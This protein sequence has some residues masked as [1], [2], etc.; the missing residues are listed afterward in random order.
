M[1]RVLYSIIF[2]VCTLT[3][4]PPLSF[5][6]EPVPMAGGEYSSLFFR[7]PRFFTFD[8]NRVQVVQKKNLDWLAQRVQTYRDLKQ[9]LQYGYYRVLRTDDNKPYVVYHPR[10]PGGGV[11]G[12]KIFGTLGGMAGA[13]IGKLVA[14]G[15]IEAT[16][17]IV[18]EEFGI[19]PEDV[20]P[21]FYYLYGT[22]KIVMTI[23]DVGKMGHSIAQ[24][25]FS[26]LLPTSPASL[27]QIGGAARDLNTV[28]NMN[29]SAE[30]TAR[31]VLELARNYAQINPQIAADIVGSPTTM[32]IDTVIDTL[33]SNIP[34][35]PEA[36]A[37]IITNAKHAT[38][39]VAGGVYGSYKSI[40]E[41]I[42]STPKEVLKANNYNPDEISR[43]LSS[44]KGGM[45]ERTVDDVV[46]NVVKTGNPHVRYGV[47]LGDPSQQTLFVKVDGIEISVPIG[48][49]VDLGKSS[50]GGGFANS[51]DQVLDNRYFKPFDHGIFLDNADTKPV[52]ES[53]G[54]AKDTVVV[55][56]EEIPVLSS[57][58]YVSFAESI[59]KYKA[60]TARS[61]YISHDEMLRQQDTTPKSEYMSHDEMLKNYD[62]YQGESWVDPRP[63]RDGRPIVYREATPRER[64]EQSERLPENFNYKEFI[65]SHT[66]IVNRPDKEQ[67]IEDIKN[68]MRDAKYYKEAHRLN[69][70]HRQALKGIKT[71]RDRYVPTINHSRGY[72][73][74]PAE[75]VVEEDPSIIKID[76]LHPERTPL[77]FGDKFEVQHPKTYEELMQVVDKEF[78]EKPFEVGVNLVEAQRYDRFVSLE[79]FPGSKEVQCGDGKLYV[80]QYLPE[81]DKSGAYGEAYQRMIA[82]TVQ[83]DFQNVQNSFTSS[84]A[85][86]GMSDVFKD[87][88][89]D[90]KS[91]ENIKDDNAYVETVYRQAYELLYSKIG[92]RAQ[93]QFTDPGPAVEE[94]M[95]RGM[96]NGPFEV[97]V[98][99]VVQTYDQNYTALHNIKD[100]MYM[101][102]MSE[103]LYEKYKDNAEFV[104]G[105]RKHMSN[106]IQE[107]KK[108]P[109]WR[110]S[111][112]SGFV[113]S[114]LAIGGV[115]FNYF[116]TGKAALAGAK[117]GSY[118]GTAF[119]AALPFL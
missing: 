112:S 62:P 104:K 26:S 81:F 98:D 28:M 67:S 66:K 99:G 29:L 105:L 58:E 19:A 12:A 27:D 52:I 71:G 13:F 101:L 33:M 73:P 76:P 97:E 77:R 1:K 108:N 55:E 18:A 24:G 102:R 61:G 118:L 110:F 10:M 3:A 9:S 7:A 119:G 87:I 8:N 88:K 43:A 53:I 15:F 31:N 72:T 49:K 39:L 4:Q 106:I 95:I 103:S 56:K 22:G 89:L 20:H 41:T 38:L 16:A 36:A 46:Y 2:F 82:N 35:D 75:P 70:D 116:A 107:L 14:Q 84:T 115:A 60:N 45:T 92:I 65:A 90:V 113:Y 25:Q 5:D 50:I 100:S 6:A 79:Q 11:L 93:V 91:L 30:E 111:I 94:A 51:I 48:N 63:S 117:A 78:V 96:Q 32:Y 80:A 23:Y 57:H 21:V 47:A 74:K 37:R 64:L 54:F 42:R 68:V 69:W 59:E 114:A 86:A 40:S 83:K 44:V 17:M 85:L 109:D 34:R